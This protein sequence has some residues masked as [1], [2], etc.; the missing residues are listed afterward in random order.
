MLTSVIGYI[1]EVKLDVHFKIPIPQF[2]VLHVPL[3]HQIRL[4]K[5]ASVPFRLLTVFQLQVIRIKIT[6]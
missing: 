1:R 5:I 4:V 3:Q 2:Y 6:V